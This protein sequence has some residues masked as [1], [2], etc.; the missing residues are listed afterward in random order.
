M[1]YYIETELAENGKFWKYRLNSEF[2]S[3]YRNKKVI[4]ICNLL[5]LGGG[6]YFN[7]IDVQFFFLQNIYQ[8]NEEP[9]L[10]LF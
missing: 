8:F 2:C 5:F 3:E 1:L 9:F 4:N 6:V 10:V 7:F